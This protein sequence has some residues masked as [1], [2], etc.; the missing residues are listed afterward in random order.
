M[1]GPV[2]I[3]L[4]SLQEEITQREDK[5]RSESSFCTPVRD[6]S[7]D[8]DLLAHR[9]LTL[10]LWDCDDTFLLWYIQAVVLVMAS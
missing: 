7:G 1:G 2:L 5:V 6:G 9:S 4:V 8:I 3:H 10:S